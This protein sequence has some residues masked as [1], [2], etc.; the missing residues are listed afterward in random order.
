MQ[1]LLDVDEKLKKDLKSRADNLK[2]EYA[3]VIG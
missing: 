1:Q 2:A 3:G